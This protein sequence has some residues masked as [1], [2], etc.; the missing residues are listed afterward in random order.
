MGLNFN[1]YS[2]VSAWASDSDQPGRKRSAS[3][4]ADVSMGEKGYEWEIVDPQGT[5]RGWPGQRPVDP[6]IGDERR[7]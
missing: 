3:D 1:R 6:E 4:A 5:R 2:N 7:R